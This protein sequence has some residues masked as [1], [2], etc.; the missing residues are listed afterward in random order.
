MSEPDKKP[1]ADLIAELQALH[2]VGDEIRARIK[3]TIAELEAN[4]A[5]I[6]E[7]TDHG[8]GE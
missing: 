5:E 1:A 6:R 7:V 4:A 2:E 8:A 3:A